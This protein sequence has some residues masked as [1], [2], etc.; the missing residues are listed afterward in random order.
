MIGR[1]TS[2]INA[3]EVSA[4][5]PAAIQVAGQRKP[6]HAQNAVPEMASAANKMYRR[7]GR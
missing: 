3:A 2:A 5:S 7:E 4:N 6:V 1:Q